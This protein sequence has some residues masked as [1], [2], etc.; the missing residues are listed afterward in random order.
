MATED[1]EEIVIDNNK[2]EEDGEND[3]GFDDSESES[4]TQAD[5]DEDSE[6][7]EGEPADDVEELGYS[8]M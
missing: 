3:L 5:E 6:V 2:G 7:E 4:S 1:E 8:V